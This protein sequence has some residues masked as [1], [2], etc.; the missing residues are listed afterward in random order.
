MRVA[1]GAFAAAVIAPWLGGAIAFAGSAKPAPPTGYPD[2]T[3]GVTSYSGNVTTCAQIGLSDDTQIGSDGAGSYSADGWDISSD[4]T[5]LTVNTVADGQQIDALVVKGGDGYNIFDSTYF[6]DKELPVGGLHAPLVGNPPKNVP[7]IS[8]WFACTGPV[9]EQPPPVIINPTGTV[10]GTCRNATVDVTAGSSAT[11]F[12]ITQGTSSTEDPVGMGGSDHV[13]LPWSGDS[14]VSVAVKGSD[15]P[16]DSLTRDSEDCD[17][18]PET[19]TN[20]N[21]AFS[22]ACTS[23]ISVVLSNMDANAPVTFTVT[24]NAGTQQ[25]KVKADS[26]R[27]LHVKVAEDTT[28]TVTVTAAGLSKQTHSYAKNCT[29]VLGEKQVRTPKTPQV[30]GEKQQLPF[31]GMP[32]GLVTALA[33]LMLAAGGALTLA[34][35]RRQ[36]HNAE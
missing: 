1:G 30:K 18:A 35:R 32:A 3:Q 33:G 10:T 9:D 15:T 36:A 29:Q 14:T 25:V 11:T 5:N 21:V 13:V 2:G 16:L 20:P 22:N 28:G 12:V 26:I 8:H 31:T 17:G 23:G 24:S 4:G 6:A 19:V 7:T 34:G 27:R